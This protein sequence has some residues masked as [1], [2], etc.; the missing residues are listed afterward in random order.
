MLFYFLYLNI[1][2]IL[3]DYTKLLLLLLNKLLLLLYLLYYYYIYIVIVLIY[4]ITRYIAHNV[5]KNKINWDTIYD[6]LTFMDD[7]I[8]SNN[9]ETDY[10]DN[11][12]TD[13]D[14]LDSYNNFDGDFK[15]YNDNDIVG[16]TMHVNYENDNKNEKQHIEDDNS[17]IR[18]WKD[19]EQMMMTIENNWNKINVDDDEKCII[20][21]FTKYITNIISKNKKEKIIKA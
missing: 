12:D 18:Y 6:G 3:I 5:L 21:D 15:R 16:T 14:I 2:H 4:M 1:S 19:I 9:M 13:N 20:N 7:I 8:V 17:I 10:D 11:I